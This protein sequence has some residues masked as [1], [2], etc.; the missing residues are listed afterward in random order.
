MDLNSTEIL[1]NDPKIN[2]ILYENECLT[3]FDVTKRVTPSG[4]KTIPIA[5]N[6]GRT[7]PAVMIGCHAGSFCCLN[8]VSKMKSNRHSTCAAAKLG[9]H[10]VIAPFGHN[11]SAMAIGT[12]RKTRYGFLFVKA[13]NSSQT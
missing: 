11:K 2:Q 3:L 4:M 5:M 7:V 13:F 8:L 6:A 12:N 10:S 1:E 9:G